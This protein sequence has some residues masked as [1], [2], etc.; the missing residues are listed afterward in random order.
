MPRYSLARLLLLVILSLVISGCS[1]P[2][3]PLAAQAEHV[4][5]ASAYVELTNTG[6]QAL[7]LEGWVLRDSD[8]K[9]TLPTRLLAP[10]ASLRIWR[11]AGLNDDANLY[12]A[13]PKVTWDLIHNDSPSIERPTFWPWDS[14]HTFFFACNLDLV[15]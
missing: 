8:G 5:A 14:V 15:R 13:H 2:S 7:R 3:F 6:A 4:C 1:S 9:Y 10:Q 12:L 11:G